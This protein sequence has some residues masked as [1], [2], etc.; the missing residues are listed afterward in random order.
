M[1]LLHWH[2]YNIP[3]AK[4][5]IPNYSPVSNKW[6]KFEIRKFLKCI[7]S[8]PRKNFGEVKKSVSITS[9]V[10]IF[11]S[12]SNFVQESFLINGD[13]EFQLL[14]LFVLPGTIARV[15]TRR[16]NGDIYSGI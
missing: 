8:K 14:R 9:V 3:H 13:C 12:L 6:T 11:S 2:G 5:D 7:D 10:F 15:D 4:D 16:F 1:I